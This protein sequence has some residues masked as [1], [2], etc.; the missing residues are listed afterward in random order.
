MSLPLLVCFVQKFRHRRRVCDLVS[1][2][3]LYYDISSKTRS[4]SKP[5]PR[6]SLACFVPLRRSNKY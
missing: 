5:L 1:L 2:P 3:Q 6:V 4:R